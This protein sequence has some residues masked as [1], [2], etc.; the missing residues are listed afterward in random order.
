MPLVDS[1]Y[2]PP[3]LLKNAHIHTVLSSLF[4]KRLQIPY[5]RERLELDDGDFID[6]DWHKTNSK[7]ILIVA[8]G[9]EGTSR[10][11]YALH[12]A[13][14]AHANGYDSV[15]WNMRGCSGVSNR[16][17]KFYHS[18]K[19]EDLTAVVK[20]VLRLGYR[21]VHL[22]GFSLGGNLTLLYLGQQGN[23]INRRIK[24]AVAVSA[25]VDLSASESQIDLKKNRIYLKRFL[26]DF[27]KKFN[28]KRTQKKIYI[29]TLR[30]KKNIHTFAELDR[31]YTAPWNGFADEQVY[32]RECSA[33]PHLNNITIPFLLLTPQDDTFMCKECYPIEIAKN[34]KNFFL[35][36]PKYGG[37]CAMLV[38][39]EFNRSYIES[40]IIDFIQSTRFF[41]G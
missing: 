41:S 40:R 18:G 20:H 26:K 39:Y 36:M 3:R 27:E 17:L 2:K 29:D 30:F 8:H 6:L 34:K 23:K 21:E 38:D 7:K 5:V 37:H 33:L 31:F 10:S 4:R 22:I 28:R 24:S 19:T 15:V 1:P 35:E 12:T 32:Y 16:K 11:S 25:P 9:M 13:N 14:A